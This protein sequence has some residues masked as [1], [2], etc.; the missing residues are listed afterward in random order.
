V[1]FSYRIGRILRAHGLAGDVVVQLFR[2]RA[3]PERRQKA[4]GRAEVGDVE[5]AIEAVQGIGPD[6][7][8]VRFAG[9]GDRD[10]A[11]AIEGAYLDVDPRSLPDSL[12]DEIDQLFGLEA[13]AKD[14][15]RIGEIVDI[16]DNGAQALLVVGEDVLIP[17]PF[18]VE[19]RDDRVVIDAPEGLLDLNRGRSPK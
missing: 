6:R 14:G 13:I 11:E 7:A 12:T 15:T 2:P 19:V 18:V 5:R 3:L 8:I 10:A 16:R 4:Q 9:I 1:A 17:A